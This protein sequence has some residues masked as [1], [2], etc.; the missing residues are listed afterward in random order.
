MAMVVPQKRWMVFIF[1]GNPNRSK[2]MMTG[3]TPMTKRKPPYEEIG[4]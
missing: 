3:S 4:I 2:W 1:L